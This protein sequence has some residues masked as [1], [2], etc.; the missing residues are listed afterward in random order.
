MKTLFLLV[1]N[2]V[3]NLIK[4][5]NLKGIVYEPNSFYKFSFNDLVELSNFLGVDI[6]EF[7]NEKEKLIHKS[8][9]INKFLK[10]IED[11]ILLIIFGIP[12][13]L[14][15]LLFSFIALIF[16]GRPVFYTQSRVGENGNY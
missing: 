16:Q 7:E 5:R 1:L 10:N 15:I 4:T 2:T 12:S 13:I 9:S 6:Y 11:V 3:S 14:L 8:T